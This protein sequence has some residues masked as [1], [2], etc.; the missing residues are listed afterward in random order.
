MAEPEAPP[1]GILTPAEPIPVQVP[2]A[3]LD[4]LREA[5]AL[6][7]QS[8]TE[9]RGL[10]EA[11]KS[12]AEGCWA[13]IE[14]MQQVTLGHRDQIEQ[15]KAENLKLVGDMALL[16]RTA[17]AAEDEVE[18]HRIRGDRA[19]AQHTEEESRRWTLEAD[20]ERWKARVA[21]LEHD[22]EVMA[23]GVGED[24][25][26]MEAEHQKA[27]QAMAE[28]VL[29]FRQKAEVMAQ[30]V[31]VEKVEKV[32]PIIELPGLMELLKK[33]EWDGRDNC[34]LCH[35]HK[36]WGHRGDCPLRPWVED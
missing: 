19:V 22:C 24:T 25:A 33:L 13:Q 20:V 14:A 27:L 6:E 8:H 32:H 28:E 3:E 29:Y 34:P 2:Q 10:L 11:T 16:A 31:E 26:D 17:A 21:D 15:L 5:L 4:A 23:Q 18:Q 30:G 36:T 12:R 9:T 1:V 7:Q 35:R